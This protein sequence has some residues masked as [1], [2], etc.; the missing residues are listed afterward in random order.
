MNVQAA[1]ITMGDVP[2]KFTA[3]E[4]I[5]KLLLDIGN[6]HD[7]VFQEKQYRTLMNLEQKK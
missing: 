3:F 7:G 6:I 1:F 4:G 2:G 5:M